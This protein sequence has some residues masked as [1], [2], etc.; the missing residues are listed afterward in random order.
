LE[1]YYQEAG[2]AGRDG[3]ESS[4]MLLYDPSDIY[5]QKY[6]I[7]Q[8]NPERKMLDTQKLQAMINYCKIK[9]CRANT[10]VYYFGETIEAPCQ[11]CDNCNQSTDLE[12]LDLTTEAQMIF[13]CIRR[14]KEKVGLS[15]V[16][17]VLRGSKSK[18]VLELGYDKLSTYGLLK[19]VEQKKLTQIC[20][21]LVEED[22]IRLE[23]ISD[24]LFPVTKLNESAIAVLKGVKKVILSLPNDEPTIRDIQPQQTDNLFEQ[25]RQLRK[26]LAEEEKVPPYVISNDATLR[27][28]ATHLPQ[29]ETAML[30]IKGWGENRQKR[31]GEPFSQIIKQ[32]S[33]Q[34]PSTSLEEIRKE[35]HQAYQPWNEQDEQLLTQMYEKGNSVKEM[36]QTLG[37]QTGGIQSRLKKLGLD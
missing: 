18:R 22:Y 1:S 8:S 25:L 20:K 7:E 13:S 14:V 31:F 2:R 26:T 10:I 9:R 5:L 36:C 30:Q 21:I 23:P 6:F 16:T 15:L 37:R 32:V 4:C 19:Q 11:M 34:N 35:H 27:Q 33:L 12:E 28:M 24:G 29:D 3:E 17:K